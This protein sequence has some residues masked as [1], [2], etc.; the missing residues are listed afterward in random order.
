[1]KDERFLVQQHK[2]LRSTAIGITVSALLAIIKGIGGVLGNSYALIADAIESTADIFTS[3]MLW[4][5]L[6]WSLRPPDKDHPYGHGKGE[7]LIALGI[8]GVLIA[9][10]ILIG[11]KSV[12]NIITPHK[13]PEAYT[14]IILVVVILAKE[15]LYRFVLKTGEETNSGA[16]KAD[17]IHHRS[18]AI[19][20]A[21]AFVGISIG[22]IGGPG[23]EVADDYAALFAA[24]VIIV[25][26]F[27]IARPA[28]GE[29]LDEELDPALTKDIKT[30]AQQVNKVLHVEQCRIRKMGSFKIADL[31]IWVDKNLTVE[32]GHR[33]SHNVKDVIQTKYPLFADVMI[34]IEPNK[35]L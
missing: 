25:N 2:G 21:A 28:I 12:Q 14:L 26:A 23:Y 34:H 13:I 35:N 27:R 5:G 9:A 24:V 31:H 29:L 16:V 3:A 1:M 4:F 19:T 8:G 33:I 11:V 10:A 20:S 32:E 6:R 22:L 17:A 30:L 18:D 7:A 15:I